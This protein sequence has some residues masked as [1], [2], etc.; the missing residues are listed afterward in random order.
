MTNSTIKARNN[1]PFSDMESSIRDEIFN[2]LE[3]VRQVRKASKRE[4]DKRT[5]Q[6]VIRE[7]GHLIGMDLEGLPQEVIDAIG[8]TI[9]QINMHKDV[10]S[11]P[12]AMQDFK[13]RV[14]LEIEQHTKVIAQRKAVCYNLIRGLRKDGTVT[15][16]RLICDNPVSKLPTGV[17]Y[18]TLAPVELLQ[19]AGIQKSCDVGGYSN[20][21]DAVAAL[22]TPT[23]AEIM[24]RDE[25]LG[26]GERPVY[27]KRGNQVPD[28]AA[29]WSK[30]GYETFN[31]P[32]GWI[33]VG[34]F[35][36]KRFKASAP[37]RVKDI[38]RAS[39]H[40]F[41]FQT[42]EAGDTIKYLSVIV[43]DRAMA[44]DAVASSSTKWSANL[45]TVLKKK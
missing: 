7:L 37:V 23:A 26:E 13:Q 10:L 28:E 8:P 20:E 35:N 27:V 1:A 39:T 14:T 25:D 31:I 5:A 43:E 22:H 18:A 29:F 6:S 24:F 34:L 30:L 33:I 15:D 44:V 32:I 21:R 11:N 2:G 38:C 42:P 36:G 9:N 3:D 16:T 45:A 17:T 12:L 4:D 40:V 19:Y 41:T